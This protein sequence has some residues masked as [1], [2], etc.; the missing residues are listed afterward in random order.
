MLLLHR[1][2]APPETIAALRAMYGAGFLDEHCPNGPVRIVVSPDPDL[3]TPV[4]A[5]TAFRGLMG[6]SLTEAEVGHL[7]ER[8][9]EAAPEHDVCANGQVPAPPTAPP[10]A[11]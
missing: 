1:P 9:R 5:V 2:D 7:F 10:S 8:C 11:N 6:D 3:P 4:A